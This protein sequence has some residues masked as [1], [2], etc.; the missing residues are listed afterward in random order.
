MDLD[1]A[2]KPSM[3]SSIIGKLSS[4]TNNS[5]ILS[6]NFTKAC[7]LVLNFECPVENFCSFIVLGCNTHLRLN[8][9]IP[10]P[11]STRNL[12]RRPLDRRT[13]VGS[14]PVVVLT[15]RVWSISSS[16]SSLRVSRLWAAGGLG[17]WLG[18]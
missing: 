16:A 7:S 2:G 6:N 18:V 8:M 5:K 12:C 3:P 4:T 9:L 17:C 11:L 14:L 1:R 13:T 15:R 10:A